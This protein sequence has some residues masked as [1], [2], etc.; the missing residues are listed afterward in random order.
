MWK[1]WT[2]AR[3]G[4]LAEYHVLGQDASVACSFAVPG[5]LYMQKYDIQG[6][7]KLDKIFIFWFFCF[8][9]ITSC[10]VIIFLNFKIDNYTLGLYDL[11]FLWFL[12]SFFDAKKIFLV[13]YFPS[14]E[15][16]LTVETL[17]VTL[18]PRMFQV[19]DIRKGLQPGMF[20]V[21]DLF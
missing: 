16:I 6:Y 19:V 7:A 1:F 10:E 3:V 20:Q 14:A 13:K 2:F 21:E 15:K 12:A 18:Q 4:F 5:P 11:P 8:L 9:R 17:K